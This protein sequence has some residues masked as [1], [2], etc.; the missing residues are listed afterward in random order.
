MERRGEFGVKHVTV[1]K[2]EAQQKLIDGIG[3]K[4]TSSNIL[5]GVQYQICRTLCKLMAN[6]IFYRD[7][8]PLKSNHAR[9]RY[10]Q[11]EVAGE[12]SYVSHH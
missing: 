4:G 6:D 10:P 5:I 8:G 3:T 7:A 1:T 2:H 11:S 12:K 9:M